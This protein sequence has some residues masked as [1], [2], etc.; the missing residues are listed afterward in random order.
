MTN[1]IRCRFCKSK[2]TKKDGIRKT[3]NRGGVQ[4]YKCKKCGKRFIQKDAFFRMRNKSNKVTLCMDLLQRGFIKENTRA[5]T[6]ILSKKLSLFYNLQ[7]D[8]KVCFSNGK[9]HRQA[10]N[11][12]WKAFRRG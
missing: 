3:E 4:R 6:S 1:K 11:S 10:E 5:S 8:N 9:L 12:I 2:E 7:M